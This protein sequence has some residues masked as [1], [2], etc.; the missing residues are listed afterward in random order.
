M[1]GERR[2]GSFYWINA[3]GDQT[4]PIEAHQRGR[5]RQDGDDYRGNAGVDRRHGELGPGEKRARS[6][7]RFS[8]SPA[9]VR[10]LPRPTAEA[11]FIQSVHKSAGAG[12]R[13]LSGRAKTARRRCVA[14]PT[15]G[16]CSGASS[17]L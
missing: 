6:R 8:R 7:R 16:A 10:L 2:M 15:P 14:T 3:K 12:R 17:S 9:A 4:G 13:N 1:A 5:A 11:T